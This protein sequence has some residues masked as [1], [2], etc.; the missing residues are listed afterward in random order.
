MGFIPPLPKNYPNAESEIANEKI[1]A[2]DYDY[3]IHS[4]QYRL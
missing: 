2:G 1:D 4:G 3:A